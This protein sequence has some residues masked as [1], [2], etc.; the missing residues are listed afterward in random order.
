MAMR[1]IDPKT[2]GGGRKLRASMDAGQP[3]TIKLAASGNHLNIC[4]HINWKTL[5]KEECT[6]CGASWPEGAYYGNGPDQCP[7]E[8]IP[9]K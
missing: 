3:I 5:A 2:R 8:C 1:V 7:R 6:D 4:S 9:K